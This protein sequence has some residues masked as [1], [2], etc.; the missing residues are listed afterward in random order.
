MALCHMLSELRAETGGGEILAVTVDHD[1]RPESSEEA[2]SVAK[3]LG[4]IGN[5]RH[6][7]LKWE[8]PKPK[9]RIMEEARSA[10][11][12]LIKEY[13]VSA[14]IKYIF[15]AHHMD[16]QAET[17]LIRL[18]KG[19]G[20]DGLA[21][22][23]EV[24]EA[25]EVFYCR[26]VLCAAKEDLIAYCH[27]KRLLYVDDPSNQNKKYMRPR[28]RSAYQVLESEGLTSKRLA[29][30]AARLRR[31]QEALESYAGSAFDD[32]LIAHKDGHI[33]LHANELKINPEEIRIRVLIKSLEMLGYKGHYPPRLEKL[34]MLAR[35]I[36]NGTGFRRRTLAGFLFT[37]KKMDG[38]EV[39]RIE[40]EAKN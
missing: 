18:A 13:A 22:M 6:T 34:E 12:R 2:G 14:G 16:D 7:V 21:A 35:E 26:P 27:D 30:T 33:I 4:A 24:Q 8:G 5:V 28:L 29:V 38:I 19:S 25:G 9:T 11:Y 37:C 40:K 31:A 3:W 23:R 36:F 20:L 15:L 1:L 17:F 32:A 39:V 10:R